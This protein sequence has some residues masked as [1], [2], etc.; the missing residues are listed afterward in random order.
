MSLKLPPM[1]T[2]P[3]KPASLHTTTAMNRI[4]AVL[5]LMEELD[6]PTLQR[7]SDALVEIK[8][9]A[10]YSHRTLIR[11][12]IYLRDT[13]QYPIYFDRKRNCYHWDWDQ[14]GISLT[15]LLKN[16]ARIAPKNLPPDKLAVVPEGESLTEGLKWARLK[17]QAWENTKSTDITRNIGIILRGCQ[18]L[19]AL[20]ARCVSILLDR[21]I[22]TDDME[23]HGRFEEQINWLR[24]GN[25]ELTKLIQQSRPE[26][27]NGK[28]LL[29]VT[30]LALLEE[31]RKLRER[32]LNPPTKT[33]RQ[34][35]REIPE[36]ME[37]FLPRL[38]TFAASNL[39]RVCAKVEA[40]KHIFQAD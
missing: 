11:D 23:S 29:S 10:R 5:E 13:C 26:V 8:G 22:R 33:L 15:K 24:T 31:L 34:Q 18:I 21:H 37:K 7:I 19:E 32:L 1:R 28:T 9:L 4:I 3:A 12:I 39:V 17:F 14:S 40:D 27:L 38:K 20:L 6:C 30:E 25:Q 35:Q 36:L 2:K 16:P